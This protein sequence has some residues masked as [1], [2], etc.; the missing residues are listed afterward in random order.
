M[1]RVYAAT[2]PLEGG[3]TG[4]C[5]VEGSATAVARRLQDA[6]AL[7]NVQSR[8][9]TRP[10]CG[11]QDQRRDFNQFV[12]KV[13]FAVEKNGRLVWPAPAISWKVTFP[14]PSVAIKRERRFVL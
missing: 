3:K 8:L 14:A 2:R 11:W 13:V 1:D 12:T 7:A 10:G 5:W 4:W 6:A 9:A